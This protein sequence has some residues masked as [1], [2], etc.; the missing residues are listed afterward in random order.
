MRILVVCE[1][2]GLG[3]TERAACAW[4]IGLARR[5]H[6]IRFLAGR[7]GPKRIL[8]E[9]AGVGVAV[10]VTAAKVAEQIR[11]F[12]PDVV[13]EHVPGFLK[14]QNPARDGRREWPALPVVQT[15]IFG[16]QDEMLAHPV[17]GI[18]AYI[19]RTSAAQAFARA[20]RRLAAPA[21]R[22]QTVVS[23]P[24]EEAPA[25]RMGA[26]QAIRRRFETPGSFLVGRFGRPDAS[27]W[28]PLYAPI[29][30]EMVRRF[31][32]VRFLFQSA[33]VE[34]KRD[35]LAALPGDRFLFLE[36]THDDVELNAAIEAC[37]A[38]LH[39]SK[40]G[41]SFGY[42]IAEA[43]RAG[44]PVVVN[45][46][47]DFDQAQLEL[48]RHG[49][50]GFHASSRRAA[51]EA[52]GRL[53][54]D[55]DRSRTLGQNAARRIREIAG[56][57]ASIAKLE[58]VLLAAA[59]RRENPFADADFRNVS[60]ARENLAR[61]ALGHSLGEHLRL[62]VLQAKGWLRNRREHLRVR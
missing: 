27:K 53:I 20:G 61:V 40:I 60:E 39:L 6:E 19:S 42:A 52:L 59:A 21:F 22:A 5:G 9:Q 48:I 56:A 35:L 47:P 45:S 8:L 23:Y 36:P 51:V 43:M 49:R 31:S 33:P 44:K 37:D 12:R 10:T 13:H 46:A 16:R 3:G 7:E 62:T 50:E 11:E 18:T 28:H 2:F 14:S 54:E 38:V 29:C 26:V 4:A 41:E 24:L 30:R 58:A 57:D 25:I 32:D 55:R 17:P 34:L 15:N 1:A